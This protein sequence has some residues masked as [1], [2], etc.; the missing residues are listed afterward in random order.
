MLNS[1]RRSTL[2]IAGVTTRMTACA[3]M[4]WAATGMFGAVLDCTGLYWTALGCNG[5]YWS[6]LVCTGMYVVQCTQP[7][8]FV[9]IR[10][11][12]VWSTDNMIF[13]SDEYSLNEH[14]LFKRNVCSKV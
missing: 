9:I 3:L 10:K 13:N 8:M 4:F 1:T 6:V 11:T 2:S 7:E 14:N 5:L 12:F